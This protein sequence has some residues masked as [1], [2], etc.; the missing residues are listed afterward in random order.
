MA[1]SLEGFIEFLDKYLQR[2]SDSVGVF[3]AAL[4]MDGMSR[5]EV[6]CISFWTLT[7][8]ALDLE[9]AKAFLASDG[10]IDMNSLLDE[11]CETREKETGKKIP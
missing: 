5:E 4:I 8:L 7:E 6:E 1:A 10:N 11:F 2:R 3:E 9:L